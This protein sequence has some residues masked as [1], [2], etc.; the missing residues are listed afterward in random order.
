MELTAKNVTAIAENCF[1]TEAELAA[2]EDR[3]DLKPIKAPGITVSVGWHSQRI[4]EN[5]ANILDLLH[6]LPCG[7]QKDDPAGG[8]SFRAA[9]ETQKGIQWGEHRDVELLF[10]LGLG[11]DAVEYLVPRE[12]W[13]VL[14][15]GLPYLR[16]TK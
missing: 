10:L 4:K 13:R 6:Q 8:L 5:E 3:E 16:L 15:G 1:F 9:C 7:F 2:V 12:M 11:I 14:P